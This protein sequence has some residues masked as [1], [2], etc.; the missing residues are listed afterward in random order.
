MISYVDGMK[1][2]PLHTTICDTRPTNET[3]SLCV[4]EMYIM[5]AAQPLRRLNGIHEEQE[6]NAEAF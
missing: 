2:A 6:R 4:T 3:C 5:T 1:N